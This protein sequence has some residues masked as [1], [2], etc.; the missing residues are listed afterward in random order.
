MQVVAAAIPLFFGGFTSPILLG[1]GTFTILF[2]ANAYNFSDGLDGLSGTLL[3]GL[4]LGMLGLCWNGH[5]FEASFATPLIFIAFGAV[6]PFLF[7]NAPK[8]K[9]FMG[10]VGSL[11]I[12]ALLGGFWF[13][14][15]PG[16]NELKRIGPE[17]ALLP[18]GSTFY[19]A[20]GVWSLMMVAELVPVPLQIASVKLRKKKIFPYTPIHHAFEKAGWPETRVVF[21]FALLQL[22]FSMAAITIVAFVK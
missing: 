4:L 2:F 19:L 22:I 18:Y 14:G 8:A 5:Q 3:L 15:F 21:V 9:V 7:W 13:L 11:P 12:G 10:D 16:P 17:P 20:L 6:I 1:L